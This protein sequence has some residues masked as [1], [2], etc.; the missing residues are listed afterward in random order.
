MVSKNVGTVDYK[1]GEIL[2]NPVI[3]TGI[4]STEGIEVQA[5]PESNDVIALRDIYL[6]LNMAKTAVN[7][8]EDTIVSGENLSGSDYAVTSSYVNGEY[9]R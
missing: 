1:K 8:I 6:E 4:S 5:I 3:F 2:L 9:T 7:I